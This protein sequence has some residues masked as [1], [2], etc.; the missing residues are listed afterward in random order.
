M[1]TTLLLENVSK[2][3]QLTSDEEE[4]FVSLLTEKTVKKRALLHKEGDVCTHST[5]VV[6][7][8]LKGFSI[9]KV[10]SEHVLHFA[11]PGW[12]IADMYSLFSEKPGVIRIEALADAHVLQ[13]SRKDQALLFKEVPK[14]ERF[15]RI[16]AENSLVAYQQR[17]LDNLSLSAEERY[18]QFTERYSFILQC[19]PLHTIA[20]YLGITPEFLSKIR[21]KISR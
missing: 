1:N 6:D 15:F 2:H 19:A 14:F 9:D 18:L 21:R 17:L 16:L 10:K 4:R 11:V 12:W 7:G 5:F 8:A 3:I 20:S 13:L